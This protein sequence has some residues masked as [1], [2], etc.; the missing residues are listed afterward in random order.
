MSD[1]HLAKAARVTFYQKAL[2]IVR[3]DYAFITVIPSRPSAARDL[4][5]FPKLVDG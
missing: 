3:C 2:L 1:N 4:P 5:A